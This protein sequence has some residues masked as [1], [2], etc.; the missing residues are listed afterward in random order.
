MNCKIT[1]E[2]TRNK[3]MG[4]SISSRAQENI[5]LIGRDEGDGLIVMDMVIFRTIFFE[6]LVFFT[7]TLLTLHFAY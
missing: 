3:Q 5:L 7:F 4:G 2:V 6:L 1:R